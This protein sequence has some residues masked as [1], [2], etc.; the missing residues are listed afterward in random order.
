MLY[1]K[2]ITPGHPIH[3]ASRPDRDAR[4]E[5]LPASSSPAFYSCS[6]L[7][8]GRLSLGGLLWCVQTIVRLPLAGLLGH[9]WCVQTIVWLPLAV[10]C[11]GDR[12]APTGRLCL[13]R[14][15]IDAS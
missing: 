4:C 11:P 10:V 7:P 13:L 12:P 8:T 2:S 3:G 6:I 15:L 14:P 5:V 1:A 9:L